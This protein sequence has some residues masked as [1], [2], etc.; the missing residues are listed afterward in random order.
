M[1]SRVSKIKGLIVIGAA[2]STMA[3]VLATKPLPTGHLATERVLG[4]HAPASLR[5][6]TTGPRADRLRQAIVVREKWALLR[7]TLL[8][9]RIAGRAM[10]LDSQKRYA[11]AEPLAKRSVELA[12][13][14]VGQ[15]D[16][17]YARCLVLQARIIYELSLPDQSVA[18]M[19]KRLDGAPPDSFHLDRNYEA[20]VLMEKAITILSR[21]PGHD[22]K[23]LDEWV[24][25]QCWRYRF[26]DRA[27]E[28]DWLRST[29][30]ATPEAVAK[31]E[32]SKDKNPEK[33][34]L[35]AGWTHRGVFLS[36]N[37]YD[38]GAIALTVKIP[39]TLLKPL[40]PSDIFHLAWDVAFEQA[41]VRW[42]RPVEVVPLSDLVEKPM[43]I[44]DVLPDS[45][46]DDPALRRTSA[47]D[48]SPAR[49]VSLNTSYF[50]ETKAATEPV[51]EPEPTVRTGA[52][53][54]AFFKAIPKLAIPVPV[55]LGGL[56]Q[57]PSNPGAAPSS[58]P[59]DLILPSLSEI[60]KNPV[61]PTASPK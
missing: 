58:Q 29:Y 4:L 52:V 51:K 28:A 26:S 24:T 61:V 32:S 38:H 12:E 59:P 56:M 57:P 35:G 22:P 30:P 50:P 45:I 9:I 53:D 48:T 6:E 3:L 16:P 17:N 46:P 25:S 33:I 5:L 60:D 49:V 19:E 14:I 18:G 13:K 36:M 7:E 44:P 31:S 27:A 2:S 15:A 41:G 10:L 21:S 55:Q 20:D 23:E 11:E 37:Y 43:P 39:I 8:W 34:I 54:P 40:V 1:A 42:T 47:V